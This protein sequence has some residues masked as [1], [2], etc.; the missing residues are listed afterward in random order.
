VGEIESPELSL[1][2]YFKLGKEKSYVYEDAHD[3]YD[4]NKGRYSY[5]TF[6][7]N[8]KENELLITQHKEG[9]FETK[10]QT[11]KINIKG[12]PFNIKGIEID[13]ETIL[14]DKASL[15]LENGLVVHKDFTEIHFIG[16]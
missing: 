1:D 6:N 3:G 15:D 13:K 4:Y 16:V 9:A 8:G 14:F 12:L 2:V 7:L 5:K 11:I 10:Y